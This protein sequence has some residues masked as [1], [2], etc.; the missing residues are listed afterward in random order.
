M[1][2]TDGYV[3][4]IGRVLAPSGDQVYLALFEGPVPT[5][6]QFREKGY[7]DRLYYSLAEPSL[8]T[9]ASVLGST[10]V[11]GTFYTGVATSFGNGQ[12]KFPITTGGQVQFGMIHR[13]ATP[14]WAALLWGSGDGKAFW[15]QP[16]GAMT[17]STAGALSGL[18]ILSVGDENSSHPIKIK[19]GTMSKGGLFTP[20]NV[21]ISYV[22]NNVIV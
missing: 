3:D 8:R 5:L 1:M 10:Y 4:L 14:T 12:A 9:I 18:A 11:A 6:D 22:G 17:A 15:Q 7:N 21:T 16:G 19:G 20:T 13:D 2:L